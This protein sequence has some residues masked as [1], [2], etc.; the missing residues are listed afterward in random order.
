M[1]FVAGFLHRVRRP[2]RPGRPDTGL[3][4][5][6]GEVDPGWGVEEGELPEIQPPD[7]PPGIWPPLTPEQPWRP[8]PDWPE[9]PSHGLPGHLPPARPGQ[10]LPPQPGQ[11][12]PP[13]EG[14]EERPDTG[15]PPG[16]IYPPL[17]P[18][19]HGKFFALVA[20][21]GMPGVKY[22][23]VVV[24]ADARWPAHP[25]QGPVPEREPK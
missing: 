14:G 3:P 16:A 11:P 19:V 21:G 5:P 2:G 6:E 1:P 23:T 4:D 22:R 8:V 13:G 18:G 17:P 15:F 7:P 25:D 20:V 9:R 12:L 24:D 10:G